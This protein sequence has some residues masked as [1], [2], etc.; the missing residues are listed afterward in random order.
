[1]EKLE[2]K[3]VSKVFEK[4]DEDEKTHALKNIN[5][6]IKNNEFVSIVG[7][8]G[9]GDSDIMMT[10]TINPLKSKFKGFHKTFKQDDLG[11]KRI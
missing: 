7:P 2:L 9:C 1:M 11:L 4:I 3:N 5:L 8:S 10:D 6:S